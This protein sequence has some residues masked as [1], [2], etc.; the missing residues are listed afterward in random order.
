MH[1]LLIILIDLASDTG[2]TYIFNMLQNQQLT[3]IHEISGLKPRA[4]FRKI[5]VEIVLKSASR[6]P[7]TGREAK[8]GPYDRLESMTME[9]CVAVVL[10][11]TCVLRWRNYETG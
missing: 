8:M 9:F 5:F 7:I 6:Q 3:L 1:N 11:W 10:S 2:K 4:D